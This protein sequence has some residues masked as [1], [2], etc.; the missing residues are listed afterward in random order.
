MT[1][2]LREIDWGCVVDSVGSGY[3]SAVGSFEHGDNLQVLA[4]LS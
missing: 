3:G 4:P 2:D 1:I